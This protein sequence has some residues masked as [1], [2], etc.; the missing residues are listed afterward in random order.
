VMFLCGVSNSRIIIET[1]AEG[2]SGW[3]YSGDRNSD[4]SS[5]IS[6]TGGSSSNSSGISSSSSI[7]SRFSA[8]PAS[9]HGCLTVGGGNLWH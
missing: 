6:S 4:R 8:Q 5:D 2:R 1:S 9:R 7:I 3:F